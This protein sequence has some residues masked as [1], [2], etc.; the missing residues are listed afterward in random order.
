MATII[1]LVPVSDHSAPNVFFGIKSLQK[2]WL[3]NNAINRPKRDAKTA[4][5][6][7][8]L[9]K[10]IYMRIKTLF[11]KERGSCEATS[12]CV[13]NKEATLVPANNKSFLTKYPAIAKVLT[14][15]HCQNSPKASR[16]TDITIIST[17]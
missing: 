3:V 6:L 2:L 14:T 12:E 1:L 13:L 9:W 11:I 17:T 15:N 4:K 10:L 8:C 7:P 5:M 16:D